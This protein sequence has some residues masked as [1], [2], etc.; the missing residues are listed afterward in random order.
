L[1]VLWRQFNTI[2]HC[3]QISKVQPKYTLS[4]NFLIFE[5]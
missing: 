5:K 2:F 4:F 1:E 3:E